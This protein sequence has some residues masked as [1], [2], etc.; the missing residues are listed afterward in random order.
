MRNLNYIPS[1]EVLHAVNFHY[2]SSRGNTVQSV[3]CADLHLFPLTNANNLFRGETVF[4][5][6]GLLGYQQ[7]SSSPGK[8]RLKTRP[9]L[10]SCFDLFNGVISS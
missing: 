3:S 8:E 2:P 5:C 6:D 4:L 9:Y 10:C 7:V 1:F